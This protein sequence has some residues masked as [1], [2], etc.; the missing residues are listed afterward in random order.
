M[1]LLDGAA[2]VWPLAARGQHGLGTLSASPQPVGI[3]Q[4]LPRP[5]GLSGEP[6]LTGR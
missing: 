5:V 4:G 2:A 1:T 3:S 6:S